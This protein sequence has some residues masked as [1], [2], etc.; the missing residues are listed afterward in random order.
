[1]T[2]MEA[3]REFFYGHMSV[4][5]LIDKIYD[6]FDKQLEDTK[7]EYYCLG[8]DDAHMAF[9]EATKRAT[10]RLFGKQKQ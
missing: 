2:R 9:K 7:K 6:D 8:S 10:E 1:M 3:K 4:S 5:S